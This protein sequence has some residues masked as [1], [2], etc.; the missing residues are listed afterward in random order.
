V[1][2]QEAKLRVVVTT[3]SAIL[4]FLLMKDQMSQLSEVHTMT[5][6][7]DSYCHTMSRNEH[8]YLRRLEA[9]IYAIITAYDSWYLT[10]I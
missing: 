2:V 1:E 7:Y 4:R 3:H 9:S 5:A 10:T 6:N 8:P